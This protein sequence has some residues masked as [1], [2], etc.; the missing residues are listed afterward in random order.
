MSNLS[1]RQE[2]GEGFIH[3]GVKTL[4]VIDQR[5]SLGSGSPSTYGFEFE[6]LINGY[7]SSVFSER[8]RFLKD[9]LVPQKYIKQ[10]GSHR[11][12]IAMANSAPWNLHYG[13]K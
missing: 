11:P 2:T 12:L 4:T 6:R 10:K 5:I 7:K 9:R 3:S 1:E 8:E 13:R